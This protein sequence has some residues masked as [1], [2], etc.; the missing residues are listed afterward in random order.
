MRR[1]PVCPGPEFHLNGNAAWE[2]QSCFHGIEDFWDKLL[3]LVEGEIED[4]F[5]V[6]LEQHLC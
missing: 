5:I 2:G 3:P 6:H 1:Q 4:E